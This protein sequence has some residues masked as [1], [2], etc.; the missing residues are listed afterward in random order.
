VQFATNILRQFGVRSFDGTTQSDGYLNAQT[1]AMGQNAFNAPT[2]FNYYQPNYTIPGT[3]LKGPEFNLLTTGSTIARANFV[4]TMLFNRIAIGNNSPSGT[5]LD[6]SEMQALAASD[7]TGNQLVNTLNGK[8]MHGT[9]SPEMKSTIL[10]AVQ[11]VADTDTLLRAQTAIYL[12][13]TS[14]QYQIQR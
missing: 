7:P 6:F 10:T 14:S 9:M 5:S 1:T 4:N 12:I 13:A 8:M 3:A 11:A 2:V